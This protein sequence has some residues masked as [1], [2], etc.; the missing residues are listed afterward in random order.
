[1]KRDMLLKSRKP[2]GLGLFLIMMLLAAGNV[3]LSY[4]RNGLAQYKSQIEL[5]HRSL[6][7]E[8]DQFHVELASLSRPERLRKLARTKLGM[9]PPSPL[10]VL[11]P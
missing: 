6:A 8:I 2:I 9:G 10:Q 7:T 11:Q 4:Y 5:A 3:S 1:M